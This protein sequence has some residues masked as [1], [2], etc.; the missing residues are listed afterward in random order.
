[1]KR[2]VI[3][4]SCMSLGM[5]LNAEHSW[6]QCERCPR[7]Y[8]ERSMKST[9]DPE[10]GRWDEGYCPACSG[11]CESCQEDSSELINAV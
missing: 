11:Y 9:F 5:Q 8:P 6:A 3:L 4:L 1:M 2:I 10:W 7:Y